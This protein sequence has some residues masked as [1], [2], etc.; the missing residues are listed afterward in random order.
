[1]IKIRKATIEDAESITDIAINVWKTTY[2]KFFKP[3]VFVR[4]EERRHDSENWW[5][6]HLNDNHDVY[7]ACEGDKVVAFMDF[8]K[9][10]RTNPKFAEVGSI[11]ILKEYQ[12]LGIGKKL[13]DK[14]FQLSK[15]YGQNK[16]MLNVLDGNS[17]LG[18][19]E[20]MGGKVVD[21]VD[22][23]VGGDDFKENVVE[24]EI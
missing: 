24:F 23:K 19:Y 9:Q 21:T 16:M 17:A 12:K 1:M 7:V 3:E 15:K 5:R 4:R 18:F 8:Y 22:I 13:F 20:K 14:A 11:Y 10:C 2:E 6:G